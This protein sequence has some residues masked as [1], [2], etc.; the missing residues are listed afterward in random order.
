MRSNNHAITLLLAMG[1]GLSYAMHKTGHHKVE[2]FIPI[3]FG[4]PSPGATPHN[5]R[6]CR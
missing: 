3:P 2:R 5:A 6:I 1:L 4:L